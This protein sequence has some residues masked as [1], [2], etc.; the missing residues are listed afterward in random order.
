MAETNRE[1]VLLLEDDKRDSVNLHKSLKKAGYKCHTFVIDEDGF[2]EE[3][4]QSIYGFFAGIFKENEAFKQRPLF[5]NEIEVPD[6]WEIKGTNSSGSIHDKD[7]ERGK[8]FYSEPK[9]DRRVHVVDWTN[10]KGIVRC[11]D[12]YNK[13]GAL[14]AR[15]IFNKKGEKVNKTY[16]SPTGQVVI[17][18]N[19]VTKDIIL[20]EGDAVR[21]FRSKKE[22]VLYFFEKNDFAKYPVYYNSLSNPFFVSEEL[23]GETK[24]DI[25]F[26]QEPKR[27]DVP[28]NMQIILK[29][30]SSRT[31]KIMVQ[32]RRAYEKLIELGVDPEIVKRLGYI[33]PFERETNYKKDILICT[34][35]DQIE[36]LKELV[37][38]LPECHFH[39][40]AIT[41]MSSKLMNF[42]RYD[43]VTLY[44][45]IKTNM[46][47]ELFA[48]CD[49]YLDINHY[50]EIFTA[51]YR[52]FL[53]NQVIFA[54]SETVHNRDYV[55]SD[56]IYN[57]DQ[58]TN[59]I[60]DINSIINDQKLWNKKIKEQKE[61]AM[62]ENVERYQQL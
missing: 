14:F 56:N 41:E 34:N 28:G 23:G 42:G 13:Y 11:C 27:E 51:V 39:I 17:E 62:A 25:L 61:Y 15:T 18:E 1:I 60:E 47:E 12:H 19:F 4:I 16:F 26:W 58:V 37:E 59:M 44:P 2:G 30:I 33:Y 53:N 55:V 29:N 10:E 8:I 3:E 36:A 38:G 24:N 57:K 22:L 5:F 54:F 6:Y 48:K 46:Q 20:N 31:R 50:V 21:I 43:N 32:N 7:K 40:S 45:N 49:I 35:S 9:H 52:A